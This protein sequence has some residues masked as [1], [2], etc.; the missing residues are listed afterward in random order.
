M[1]IMRKIPIILLVGTLALGVV[2]LLLGAGCT[3]K[4]DGTQVENQKPLIWFVNVPPENNQSS[5]NPIVNWVG[6]DVD[7]QIDFYRYVVVREDQIAALVGGAYDPLTGLT[8]QQMSDYLEGGIQTIPDT[9]WTYLYVD[10]KEADPKTNQVVPMEA[11]ISN[12]VILLVPQ[13]VFIQAFDVAGLGS[14]IAYRRFF[15]NDNPPETY[16]GGYATGLQYINAPEPLGVP[17]TGVRLEWSGADRIDH[18]AEAP[19]FEFE[20]K[21]FGPYDDDVWETI[22]DEFMATVFVTNDAQIFR[23]GVTDTTYPDGDQRYI[24]CD[25]SYVNGHD[26]IVCET[27]IVDSI[28]GSNIYGHLDT[29]FAVHDSSFV[30]NPDFYRVADSSDDGHGNVWVTDTR[31][32][33]W[34]LFRNEPSD[35]SVEMNMVFW[36]RAR[37]D[38]L[39]PDLTPEFRPIRVINPL[40]ERDVMVIDAG[41][42]ASQVRGIMDS[43]RAYWMDAVNK[44]GATRPDD[45][46]LY[47]SIDFVAEGRIDT[48]S[49]LRQILSHKILVILSDDCMAGRW[50]GAD[51]GL[52]RKVASIYTGL[53]TGVNVWAATRTPFVGN[54]DLTKPTYKNTSVLYQYHFG[55]EQ[56][57]FSSWGELALHGDGIEPTV[58]I[59]D[60]QGALSMNTDLWPDITIDSALLHRRYTYQPDPPNPIRP[61][62]LWIPELPYLSEVDWLARSTDTDVMFLYNSAYGQNHWRGGQYSFHGR[63]VAI[64]LNRGLFR[65]VSWLFTPMAFDTLTMQPVVNEV[66]NW[67][68]DGRY[69]FNQGTGK[70]TGAQGTSESYD[71]EFA[72][73]FREARA[74]ARTTDEFY[75]M[76]MD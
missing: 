57:A 39:V 17:L 73:R 75:R 66:F 2:A 18:P 29:I 8:A 47:D 9:L 49:L 59:E 1:N 50:D 42:G 26:S 63:P 31:D 58:R 25:T 4:L 54:Q 45:G 52:V 38:A 62:P 37:D 13:F 7:G 33:L 10:P 44:W 12:P 40:H 61:W 27:L 21:C 68:Y 69:I 36:V 35:T 23:L 5:V 22:Q 74:T 43:A 19:P 60:F 11:E 71:N 51:L 20:W 28:K 30:S 70:L 24:V 14:D 6:R 48:L 3:S 53:Q 16:I 67:L 56:V 65:T 64:R 32:S 15:R 72:R 55:V 41:K 46:I 76:L 34:N